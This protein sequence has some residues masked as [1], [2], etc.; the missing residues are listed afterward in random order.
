MT[1]CRETTDSRKTVTVAHDAEPARVV[2]TM[3]EGK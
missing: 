2:E 1:R 3:A